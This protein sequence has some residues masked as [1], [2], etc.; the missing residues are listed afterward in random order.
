[1][2]QEIE[3]SQP[4]TYYQPQPPSVRGM[5]T[6][7]RGSRGMLAATDML[8]LGALQAASGMTRAQITGFIDELQE[9]SVATV[10]A[11]MPRILERS[12][13]VTQARINQLGVRVNQLRR[14][15]LAQPQVGIRGFLGMAP[16]R[17]LQANAPEYI[18]LAEVQM[19]LSEAIA[20]LSD[21]E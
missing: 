2:T 1:M 5:P 10:L 11:A 17:T 18:S 4:T 8:D 12:K 13:R 7:A 6:N 15:Q 14:I 3:G 19:I 16:D 21:D 20:A 9:V